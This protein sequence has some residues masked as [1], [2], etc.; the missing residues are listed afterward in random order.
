MGLIPEGEHI[1]LAVARFLTGKLPFQ[2]PNQ[3]LHQSADGVGSMLQC[4]RISSFSF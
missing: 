2:L 3:Q 4:R 1:S